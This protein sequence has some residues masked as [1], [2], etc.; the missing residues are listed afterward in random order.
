MSK[1]WTTKAKDMLIARLIM[2]DYASK[3]QIDVLGL[4]ELVFNKSEKR[5]DF[6]LAN[7]VCVL[8]KQFNTMYG[9]NQG[10]YV[11]RQVITSCMTQGQTLH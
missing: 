5:M 1:D 7:W 11:T 10:E 4:F 2:E 3:K 8:V 9:A 6:R